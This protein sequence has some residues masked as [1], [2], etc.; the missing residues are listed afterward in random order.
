MFDLEQKIFAK[1]LEGHEDS[2]QDVVFSNDNKY[3]VSAGS[4]ACV[5]IWQ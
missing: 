4:D 1:S 2:V 3:L 5:K